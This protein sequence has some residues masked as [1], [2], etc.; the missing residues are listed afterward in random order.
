M[1]IT[2]IY[3]ILYITYIL[4]LYI[5]Y[6]ISYSYTSYCILY[7]L[8]IICYI[9]LSTLSFLFSKLIFTLLLSV[10]VYFFVSFL[11]ILLSPFFTRDKK[12]CPVTFLLLSVAVYF[13][14]FL[15]F[16]IILLSSLSRKTQRVLLNIGVV[17]FVQ[18]PLCLPFLFLSGN[19]MLLRVQRSTSP[20]SP[21]SD[22]F[23]SHN[24]NYTNHLHTHIRSCT[25][26]VRT[27]ELLF[28]DL[29]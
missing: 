27:F 24:P 28:H 8:Y 1:H 25:Q 4:F 22:R 23:F 20:F 19:F 14:F 16:L 17:R 29:S 26:Y 18:L 3:L 15:S 12:F 9:Y 11:I 5:L 6:Y 21:L 7:T 10:A 13:F 2:L